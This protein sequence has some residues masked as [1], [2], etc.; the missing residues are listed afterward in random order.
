MKKLSKKLDEQEYIIVEPSLV[1]P[2]TKYPLIFLLHGYGSN[3]YDLANL[4]E[5]IDS[6][7]YI[8]ICPNAPF[9][10]DIGYESKGFSWF[11][12]EKNDISAEK[13]HYCNLIIKLINLI[14]K[15]YN[16][17]LNKMILGG[18]SQGAM[19]T[20]DFGFSMHNYFAGLL[21]MSGKL[22]DKE[23]FMYIDKNN[24]DE[25]I[26]ISHG[27]YDNV[28]SVNEGREA[29]KI[30]V[31][32]GFEVEYNEYPIAHEISFDVINDMKIWIKRIFD[33]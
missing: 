12:L 15:E 23:S 4:C 21:A 26:F 3:M 13:N 17:D 7:K 31:N 16:I 27:L 14:D 25:K 8:Y 2:N 11:D 1:N 19:V 6:D 28:I 9:K 20:Y 32:R 18:F 5:Y 22:R 29:N 24:P 30:L 10:M 33:K